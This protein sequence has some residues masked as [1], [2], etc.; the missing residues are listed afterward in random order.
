MDEVK[1]RIKNLSGHSEKL[2]GS[3]GT[4]E[5]LIDSGSS[6]SQSALD[7]I[8]TR[9]RALET[10]E[11]S[12]KSS[13]E[14]SL[15]KKSIAA[16]LGVISDLCGEVRSLQTQRDQTTNVVDCLDNCQCGLRNLRQDV[17]T[18]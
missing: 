8:I 9:L 18:M 14:D 2:V 12:L 3:F 13:F 5:L 10:E 6:R 1:R 11:K 7:G 16:L 17:T 15:D 4:S